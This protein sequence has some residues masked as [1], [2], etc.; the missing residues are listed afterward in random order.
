MYSAHKINIRVV[1]HPTFVDSDNEGASSWGDEPTVA[2]NQVSHVFCRR[3]RCRGD[4]EGL[5]A[6]THAHTHMDYYY[7]VGQRVASEWHNESFIRDN[8]F[9]QCTYTH[10]RTHT[11]NTQTRPYTDTLALMPTC[12]STSKAACE[13]TSTRQTHSHWHSSADGNTLPCD[14]TLFPHIISCFVFLHIVCYQNEKG[15]KNLCLISFEMHMFW[16]RI[17]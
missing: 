6:H 10:S 13:Y 7:G 5:C 1:V 9:Y 11:L 12:F 16:M 14:V 8:V 3:Q 17:F 15:W 4:C 2:V